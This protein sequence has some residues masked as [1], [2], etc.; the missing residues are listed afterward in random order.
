MP[1]TYIYQDN[2][3]PFCSCP[4]CQ[5]LAERARLH[6]EGI[7]ARDPRRRLAV[8]M[9]LALPRHTIHPDARGFV[10]NAA[11]WATGLTGL[12]RPPVPEYESEPGVPI[13][14]D[15]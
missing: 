2:H 6:Q 14:E 4:E 1:H 5:E 10:T 8:D 11:L 13:S 3:D 12:N 7:D 15:R 9:L